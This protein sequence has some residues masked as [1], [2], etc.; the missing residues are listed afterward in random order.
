MVPIRIGDEY[1][2]EHNLPPPNVVKID[3]EGFEPQV[4]AGLRLTIQES[5]PA[6]VLEHIWLSDEQ[7]RESIPEGYFIWFIMKEG[8]LSADFRSR[9]QDSNAILVHTSDPRTTA[10]REFLS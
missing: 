4:L 9:M 8:T 5:K 7:L 1:R 6:I 3:V 10:L 2:R